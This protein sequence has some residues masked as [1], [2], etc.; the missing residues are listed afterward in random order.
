MIER[1]GIYHLEELPTKQFL[2]CI[3]NLN[4]FSVTEKLDGYELIFGFDE[5]GRFYT[6]REAKG[7]KQ[8]FSG[9]DYPQ[10]YWAES[11]K[12]AHLCL[13]IWK[14][15]LHEVMGNDTAI[16]IELLYGQC[17]NVIPYNPDQINRM[18]LLRNIQGS[19]NLQ[20]LKNKIKETSVVTVTDVPFT[21][22]GYDKQYKIVEQ[23]WKLEIVPQIRNL[24]FPHKEIKAIVSTLE[25]YLSQKNDSGILNEDLEKTRITKSNK[26]EIIAIRQKIA[27]L[28]TEIKSLLTK[29][30][31]RN[32]SSMF[33]PSLKENGWIEGYVF[34]E[35]ITNFQFKLVDKE[36]FT[37]INNQHHLIQN[38]V[39][40]KYWKDFK[41]S[42]VEAVN[43]QGQK[44]PKIVFLEDI[45][46]LTPS[47]DERITFPLMKTK[48]NNILQVAEN[49][50]LNDLQRLPQ[51]KQ[52][53]NSSNIDTILKEFQ[54]NLQRIRY[55]RSEVSK[56]TCNEH[57]I[58][59]AI[60]HKIEL[61]HRK[62]FYENCTSIFKSELSETLSYIAKITGIQEQEIKQNILGST[63][64]LDCSNDIDICVDQNKYTYEQITNIVNISNPDIK[65]SMAHGLNI[66]QLA[67]PIA[68]D[69]TKG[70]VQTDLMFTENVDWTRFYYASQPMQSNYKGAY[71]NILLRALV[72][73]ENQAE[74]ENGELIKRNGFVVVPTIG[75]V[76]QKRERPWGSKGKRLKNFVVKESGG[77]VSDPTSVLRLFF[78]EGNVLP[79]DVDTFEKLWSHINEEFSQ[80]HVKLIKEIATKI[81]TD[82]KYKIPKEFFN[83]I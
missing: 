39:R 51:R 62:N 56:A 46:D 41:K 78:Q 20:N 50:L 44:L 49:N 9:S 11:F 61:P 59:L 47:G 80:T 3:K 4:K 81:L 24:S 5:T 83:V 40:Q 77:S 31:I 34:R 65:V 53:I 73:S 19:T 25:E 18:V 16:E 76:E 17:P 15:K 22:F 63:G 35:K 64:K 21:S 29:K 27:A 45:E 43:L 70:Y 68:G 60:N 52:H 71:R 1:A 8:Y 28:K 32:Q 23:A 69:K 67:V 6:S 48:L 14:E 75:I 72:A 2:E 42:L 55:M 79:E 33:G 38:E 74:Y 57:L 10:D 36:K 37:R 54:T 58:E 66:L 7:G 30:V 13:E 26:D 12:S 82:G